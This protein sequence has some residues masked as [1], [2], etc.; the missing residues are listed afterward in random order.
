VPSAG[1]LHVTVWGEGDSAVLVHGSMGTG[2]EQWREQ[3]PLA[4]RYRLLVVDRRGY[5]QSLH[6]PSDFEQDAADVAA[7][8]PQRAHVLGLS[9]GAVVSLLAASL[10]PE[11]VR[12]L[13]VIEP[14]A[15]GLVR[16]RPEVEDFIARVSDA[17]REA[18][19]GSD[20]AQRFRAAFG[21]P[22]GGPP[23]EGRELESATTSWH[24]RPPWEAEIPIEELARAPFPKLVVRGAWDR[25]PAEARERG[26]RVFG[27]VCDVLVER[28]GAESAVLPGAA[29]SAQLLG[30]PFNERLLA[31][32]DSA[33]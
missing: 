26:G 20:Y 4:E 21:I 18:S 27:A 7:L 2:E 11:R 10:R 32:W 14:P 19:D 9:Y 3:K 13:T 25:V 30:Q 17:T 8:L 24:E 5:G 6:S 33:R 1:G 22:T 31:F 23:L 29:H 12:S 16:G 28:L 15:F